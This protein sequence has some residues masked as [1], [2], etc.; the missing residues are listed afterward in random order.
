MKNSEFL[1]NTFDIVEKHTLS[2]SNE[3]DSRHLLVRLDLAKIGR[4]KEFH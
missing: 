3:Q 1:K 2:V 4:A